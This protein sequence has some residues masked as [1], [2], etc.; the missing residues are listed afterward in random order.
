MLLKKKLITASLKEENNTVIVIRLNNI[1]LSRRSV[2]AFDNI[3]Q[4]IEYKII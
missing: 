1:D 4:N 3:K 2:R